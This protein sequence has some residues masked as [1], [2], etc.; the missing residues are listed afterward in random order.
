MSTGVAYTALLLSETLSAIMGIV[1]RW[2]DET[3][4]IKHEITVG[5]NVTEHQG[6][7]AQG[8]RTER[9]KNEQNRM[10]EHDGTGH[11]M[12]IEQNTT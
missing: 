7:K 1:S 8:N 10:D 11:K 3:E 12:E 2:M 6:S 5:I 4:P 9:N